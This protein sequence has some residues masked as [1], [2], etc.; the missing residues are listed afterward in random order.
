MDLGTDKA[1]KPQE[2]IS[3]RGFYPSTPRKCNLFGQDFHL[4]SSAGLKALSQN[5]SVHTHLVSLGWWMLV[6]IC[7]FHLICMELGLKVLSQKLMNSGRKSSKFTTSHWEW[8]WMFK[9]WLNFNT[10]TL[11]ILVCEL[12][13]DAMKPFQQRVLLRVM[14]ANEMIN[15]VL[16]P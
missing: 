1:G 5:E 6:L 10:R 14:Q 9:I 11:H 3:F 8:C 12:F 7:V 13:S 4:G 15:E 2:M 16:S